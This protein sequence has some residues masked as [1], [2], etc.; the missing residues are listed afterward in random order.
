MLGNVWELTAD[1]KDDY[2]SGALTDPRGPATGYYRVSRGG[3][4]FDVGPAVNATFRASPAPSDHASS[5]GFRIAR[6]V[7]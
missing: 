1:W 6:D 5:L 7:E 4:W 2:P 3:S